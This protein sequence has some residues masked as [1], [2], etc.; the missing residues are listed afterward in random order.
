MTRKQVVLTV[1]KASH[2][3]PKFGVLL[4]IESAIPATNMATMRSI[5]AVLKKVSLL[6]KAERLKKE[7]GS[8]D[9]ENSGL[10]EPL[11]KWTKRQRPVERCLVQMMSIRSR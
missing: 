2:T 11:T 3:M 5:V 9:A 6:E 4:E 8:K 1:V 10:H 7:T